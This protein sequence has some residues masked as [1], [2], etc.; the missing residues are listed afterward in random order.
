MKLRKV[1]ASLGM[2]VLAAPTMAAKIDSGVWNGWTQISGTTDHK[3]NVEDRDFSNGGSFVDPG[4]GGQKFDAEYLFYKQEGS[5]LSIGLQTGFDIFYDGRVSYNNKGYYTGDL[6]LSFDGDADKDGTL[7]GFE[8]AID[9]GFLT[10]DY[11]NDR[12]G[13]NSGVQTEGLYKVNSWNNDIYFDGNP[14]DQVDSS[15]FAVES[16]DFISGAATSTGSGKWDGPDYRDTSF[17]RTYDI[18]LAVL[19]AAEGLSILDGFDLDVHWTMSCGNDAID[20]SVKVS[21]VPVPP[22]FILM[23]S[24]LAGFG[25]LRR[26]AK[27]A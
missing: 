12:V 4:W 10:R 20:G 2:L 9:F 6:A 23:G 26:K 15:P 1:L 7:S 25:V 17:Y 27:R 16:G 5:T 14:S 11:W 13:P 22:A 24:L 3:G 21:P 19:A 18:D 8:Y